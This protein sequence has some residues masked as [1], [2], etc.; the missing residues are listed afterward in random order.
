MI[1]VTT[2]WGRLD[3]S[4]RLDQPSQYLD[5]AIVANARRAVETLS[6]LQLIC[7]IELD[8]RHIDSNNRFAHVDRGNGQ[9]GR[10]PMPG[11]ARS[12][13][14]H[15]SNESHESVLLAFHI[16][17]IRVIRGS[18]I[19]DTPERFAMLS[20]V[21]TIRNV[22][23]VTRTESQNHA[24]HTEASSGSSLMVAVPLG[25]GDGKRSSWRDD[26]AVHAL[27]RF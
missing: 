10:M 7:G 17:V 22:R 2:S 11:D 4:L 6:P 24:M 15:E 3:L 18:K 19:L 13:L 16:R 1:S 21:K 27:G 5:G 8:H 20:L 26:V 25:P 9:R 14:D 23:V 12:L